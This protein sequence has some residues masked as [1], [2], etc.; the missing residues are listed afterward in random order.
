MWNGLLKSLIVGYIGYITAF[1]LEI[2]KII[3][4]TSLEPEQK[5]ENKIKYQNIF[6]GIVCLSFALFVPLKIKMNE[7]KLQTDEWKSKYGTITQDLAVEY[8][9]TIHYT[10]WVIARRLMMGLFL[11]IPFG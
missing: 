4:S 5:D 3:A 10:S 9:K 8:P 6:L 11:L 7:H 1:V 2:R